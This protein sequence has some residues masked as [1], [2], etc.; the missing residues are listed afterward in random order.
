MCGW[1]AQEVARSSIVIMSQ[2]VGIVSGFNASGD[3][4][5]IGGQRQPRQRAG[6]SISRS[7]I[8]GRD[9]G[10]TSV[11]EAVLAQPRSGFDRL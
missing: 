9:G 1:L 11:I 3:P 6:A 10:A 8:P 7:G 4:D 5:L 2:H